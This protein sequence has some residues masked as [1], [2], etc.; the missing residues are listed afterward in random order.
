MLLDFWWM[1]MRRFCC[2]A[3]ATVAAIGIASIASAADMPMKARPAPVAAI[4]NWTG[5]YIGANVGGG[6]GNRNVDY[7]ANDPATASVFTSGG[8]PP[9]TSFRTS[10]LLGGLQ[11]GYNWQER[12]DLARR[13]RNRFR[14]VGNERQRFEQRLGCGPSFPIRPRSMSASNGSAPCAPVWDICRH[15]T[16]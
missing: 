12:A 14:L 2:A 7:T 15:R 1:T 11:L 16:S 4:Y 3:L 5:F 6:W 10:G 13:S 9:A 8:Q